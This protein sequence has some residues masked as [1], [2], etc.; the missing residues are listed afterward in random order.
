MQKQSRAFDFSAI[1]SIL[2]QSK[3]SWR[4]E[5]MWISILAL[6]MSRDDDVVFS[7]FVV[8]AAHLNWRHLFWWGLWSSMIHFLLYPHFLLFR[9]GCLCQGPL[10]V[11]FEL[12]RPSSQPLL[13]CARRTCL[14]QGD[15]AVYP[16]TKPLPKL[17]A[18]L[19]VWKSC[20]FKDNPNS[21]GLIPERKFQ[22]FIEKIDCRFLV[23]RPLHVACY[24]L[25]ERRSTWMT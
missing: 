1:S 11:L 7:F 16:V 18:A 15:P 20:N 19:Q 8:R 13:D 24:R 14:L 2:I 17:S 25:L 22:L 4:N 21:L 12:L 10:F 9:K 3:Q 23:L 5:S 6:D